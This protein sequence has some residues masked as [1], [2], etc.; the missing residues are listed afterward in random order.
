MSDGSAFRKYIFPVVII[1]AL[2]W[3]ALQTLGGSS[4][5]RLR[6]SDAPR[7]SF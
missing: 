2:L 4:H 1:P 6:F 7:T 3:L 5:Q